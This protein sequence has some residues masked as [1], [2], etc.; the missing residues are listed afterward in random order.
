MSK[1]MS[2]VGICAL[3]VSLLLTSC[4]S[5]K[6]PGMDVSLD[7]S[8]TYCEMAVQKSPPTIPAQTVA[9][10]APTDN[11]V[12]FLTLITR[13]ETE[14]KESLGGGLPEG[15]LEKAIGREFSV[16]IADGKPRMLAKRSV[17]P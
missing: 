17:Q 13:S 16:V 6:L 8:Q 7:D 9:I 1:K 2:L 4:S 11:F 14:V 12:D 10:L 3:T 15:E 5:E